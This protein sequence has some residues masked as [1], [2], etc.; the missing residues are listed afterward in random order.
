MSKK[1][2]LI[3]IFTVL[4]YVIFI[5]ISY[6][7]TKK[8]YL[9]FLNKEKEHTTFVFKEC[10]SFLESWFNDQNS[11]AYLLLN[12][13][14]FKDTYKKV[15]KN[16]I[17]A[18]FSEFLSFYKQ[19]NDIDEILLVDNNKKVLYGQFYDIPAKIEKLNT[20]SFIIYKRYQNVYF[21]LSYLVIDEQKNVAG[22]IF[23]IYDFKKRLYPSISKFGNN[24]FQFYFIQYIDAEQRYI[25]INEPVHFGTGD[26]KHLIEESL[27]K[28]LFLKT[29]FKTMDIDSSTYYVIS[30]NLGDFGS[31][32]MFK[33]VSNFF[34]MFKEIKYH[35]LALIVI[36]L[37]I[38]LFWVLLLS[39]VKNRF[40]KEQLENKFIYELILKSI[41][42]GVIVTDKTGKILIMNKASEDLTGW[43]QR[44][45]IGKDINEVFNI[46]NEFTY[47]KVENPVKT[48]ILDGKI[49]GLANHTLLIRKDGSKISIADSASPIRDQQGE[50][51]GAVLVFRDYTDERMFQNLIDIK[52][53]LDEI[54]NVPET[55]EILKDMTI[56][57]LEFFPESIVVIYR[58]DSKKVLSYQNITIEETF[59]L[60]N[61][62]NIQNR[63]ED[64]LIKE[65][66]EVED[67]KLVFLIINKER[68]FKIKE[69]NG[70]K[71]VA[72][73]IEALLYHKSYEKKLLESKIFIESLLNSIPT[74]VFYKDKN[75]RYLGFN[76]AFKDFY[77]KGDELIGK[78]VFDFAPYEYAKKYYEMD[79]ELFQKGGLQV[80]EFKIEDANGKLHDVVFH[81]SLFFD[82]H[83]NVEGL[84]GVVMDETE[85][86]LVRKHFENI[87]YNM[88]EGYA[89]HEMIYDEEGNPEDYI[90]L[91]VNPAFE[92]LTGLKASDIVG[93][94]V[95]EVIPNLER[96]WIETYG[97]IAK[98]CSSKRFEYF[99]EPLNKKFFVSAFSFEKG[100]FA[101]IFFDITE[102]EEIKRQRDLL[103]HILENSLNEIYLFSKETFQIIYIN[104]AAKKN[105]GYN[106]EELRGKIFFHLLNDNGVK[107]REEIENAFRLG[108]EKFNF[109][110]TFKRNDGSL[111]DAFVSLQYIKEP[112]EI[113]Y[114][115]TI[116]ISE[117]IKKDIELGKLKFAIDQSIDGI[118]MTDSLGYIT[119]VN[120][121][122][123]QMA[124]YQSHQIIGKEIESIVAGESNHLLKDIS[125]KLKNRKSW[126]GNINLLKKDGESFK[127]LLAIT[128]TFDK[129][130][131][132]DNI[133]AIVKD[134]TEYHKLEE[135]YLQ[136][137]KI[138]AIGR[139]T[140]GIA[141]DFNNMLTGI[142]G[143]A[144]IALLNY[145]EYSD[146]GKTF[147]DIINIAEK[148][149]KLIG[150]LLTF[151]RKQ[152]IKPKVLNLNDVINETLKML[153][154]VLGEN[155]TIILN[156][157]SP[158]WNVYLDETQLQQVLMNMLINAKDAI[159]DF[160]KIIIETKNQKIDDQF[161]DYDSEFTEKEYVK[162]IISDTG[163]GMD[164]ETLKHIFEPFF[165][166]KPIGQGT[167]LGLA[168]VYGIVKQ[169]KGVI[170]VYSELGMGTSFHI[171]FPRTSDTVINTKSEKKFIKKFEKQ[172]VTALVV[173]DDEIV[174]ELFVKILETMNIKN[175][176]AK[177]PK[178]AL[179]LIDIHRDVKIDLIITDIVLP[180]M[181]GPML[182]EKIRELQQDIKVIFTSGYTENVLNK[183]DISFENAKFLQK[184]FTI[185][186]VTDI[187][188]EILEET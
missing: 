60:I 19:N 108:L 36:F 65:S 183:I 186:D 2:K 185:S 124:G 168:T 121:G 140:G 115:I 83:G 75:G 111:Y 119:Y 155:L 151:S 144:E 97:E 178:E 106:E 24:Q 120:R 82:K 175:L 101:T 110:T 147:K 150:Q 66:I 96:F 153:R 182:V 71:T 67:G 90:F 131:E 85:L 81:K 125:I 136:A 180:D 164:K 132:F 93:K 33:E 79:N 62:D 44:E 167:G 105:L 76:R 8:F 130:N 42:D 99:S 68:R 87:F 40:L 161:I 98:K 177:T 34:T 129:E 165:T 16:N 112:F 139:L 46:V 137:Q 72:A 74:P 172:N 152:I 70:V 25:N 37:L 14:F 143:K 133:L 107:I 126:M 117:Q 78:T 48:A 3:S 84:I 145:G 156:L 77:G 162:L 38:S 91:Y 149:A 58:S 53:Y 5:I 174:R 128:P 17:G 29:D 154:S 39:I 86:N 11:D 158:L 49:S 103:S 95:L 188:R 170:K 176:T 69:I 127:A 169:N 1:I 157:E 27:K 142:I 171:Y 179:K 61:D 89:Y 88:S 57:L 146:V 102:K 160:G 18:N 59:T 7:S 166:T 12:S 15:L 26:R 181:T 113:I 138:D 52:S 4:V 21:V 45:V 9:Q 73:L 118:L 20:Q 141:H 116:D 134:M 50:T 114:G 104:K 54:K 184:P 23:L 173:E 47:E 187:I 148:A 92:K 6:S 122:F 80:Y 32:V 28:Q 31:L 123:E 94:S 109:K 159:K 35:I 43:H 63:Y 10:Y 51:L 56:K 163:C 13:K 64:R 30:K 41:G 100:K 55:H 22:S 135:R